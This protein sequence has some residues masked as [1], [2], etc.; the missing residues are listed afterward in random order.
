M[1]LVLPDWDGLEQGEGQAQPEMSPSPVPIL[2][3]LP[4]TGE[5]EFLNPRDGT[6]WGVG[7]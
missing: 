1:W 3:P 4:F 5:T 7:V 2:S 6:V